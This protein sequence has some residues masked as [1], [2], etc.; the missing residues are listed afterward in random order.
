MAGEV[1]RTFFTK[2]N[3]LLFAVAAI[4]GLIALVAI[5]LFKNRK[6]QLKF[7]NIGILLSAALVGLEFWQIGGFRQENSS[8]MGSY[9]WG[10]ILPIILILFF[11]M[12][13]AGI[14]KDQK[15]IKS[16]DRLR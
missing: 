8:L 6:Q 4:I 3:L 15:L 7:T 13:S 5:F 9:A 10:A 16:L 11:I 12:A 14:R 1:V 2:E